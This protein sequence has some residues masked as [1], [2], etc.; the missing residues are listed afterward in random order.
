MTVAPHCGR[1]CG[2]YEHPA[3]GGPERVPSRF[4]I[5]FTAFASVHGG[6]LVEG[7]QLFGA[8][9]LFGAAAE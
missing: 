9:S 5:F 6:A 1:C 8:A 3:C 7:W 4:Q 2:T